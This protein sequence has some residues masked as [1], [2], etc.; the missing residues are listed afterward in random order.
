MTA[1][2]R[3]VRPAPAMA[4]KLMASPVLMIL[5]EAFTAAVVS[6]VPSCISLSLSSPCTSDVVSEGA[7]V[8]S[9]GACVVSEETVALLSVE[10]ATEDSEDGVVAV[11]ASETLLGSE[12]V[13]GVDGVVTFP[14]AGGVGVVLSG[15]LETYWS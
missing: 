7:A 2:E 11:L 14:F 4:R 12:G 15:A 1:K 9:E 6:E 13:L 3:M 8:L 10:V 5:P